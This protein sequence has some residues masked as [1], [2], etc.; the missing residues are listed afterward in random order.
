M[1]LYMCEYTYV[2]CIARSTNQESVTVA[3]R[4]GIKLSNWCTQ[5]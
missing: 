2:L 5:I 3:G 4:E 1:N